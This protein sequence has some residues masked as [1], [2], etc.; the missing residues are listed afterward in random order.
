MD[1]R[2]DLTEQETEQMDDTPGETPE[3]AHRV[4]EYDAVMAKLDGM[5]EVL[6]GM[7][8]KVTAIS[9]KMAAFTSMAVDAG[10]EVV[11]EPSD[12]DPSEPDIIEVT[13]LNLD[14]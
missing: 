11:D 4:G 9:D 3:E 13:E 7:V 5:A 12:E 6:S 1:E 10:A 8:E 2:E 14:M